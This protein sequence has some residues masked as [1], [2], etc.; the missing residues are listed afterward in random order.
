MKLSILIPTVPSRIDNFFPAIIKHVNSQIDKLNRVDIELIGLL[1]NKRRKVGEKRNNLLNLAKG[2]Y[3]VF[4]DDDDR[5]SDDY[6][7]SIMKVLDDGDCDCIVF[8]SICNIDGKFTY[9]CKYG[10]EYD[11]TKQGKDW[12]GKP[13]HT[14]VYS[15]IIAKKYTFPCEQYGEDKAWV[16]KACLEIKIQKRI[17]KVL[18]FYDFSYKTSETDNG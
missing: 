7:E 6:V 14:M 18:Y 13:A 2:Q 17:N 15:S 1:D 3:V 10:I 9:Y 11:Y 12:F 8:D 16:K 4:I 5:V